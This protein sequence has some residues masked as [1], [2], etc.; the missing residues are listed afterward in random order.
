MSAEMSVWGRARELL[1]VLVGLVPREF[2]GSG[3][4]GKER[5]KPDI[6]RGQ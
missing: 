3:G 6:L 2:S 1:Q 4:W 5:G